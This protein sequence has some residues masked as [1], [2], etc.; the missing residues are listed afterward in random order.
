MEFNY[1]TYKVQLETIRDGNFMDI[2]TENKG[3]HDVSVYDISGDGVSR[4]GDKWIQF[5]F[6]N[7]N[8]QE[9]KE[10]V[11]IEG[12]GA[13]R[14]LHLCL[15]CGFNRTDAVAPG[16]LIGKQCRIVLK[17]ETGNDGKEYNRVD[18]FEPIPKTQNRTQQP[19]TQEEKFEF[20]GE[21]W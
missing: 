15:A 9:Q 11:M 8:G 7:G 4:K 17:K 10:I 21:K 12:G 5:L 6:K 19:M 14:Y 18:R 2:T 1:N 16:D 3:I 13:F 20:P